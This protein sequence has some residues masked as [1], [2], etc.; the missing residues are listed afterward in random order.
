ML[1]VPYGYAVT[2]DRLFLR[3][4]KYNGAKM[5]EYYQ[6]IVPWT[7]TK[8]SLL[9][10]MFVSLIPVFTFAKLLMDLQLLLKVLL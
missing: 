6:E 1:E 10:L 3:Q 8:E 4:F 9:S 2:L 7:T 5:V